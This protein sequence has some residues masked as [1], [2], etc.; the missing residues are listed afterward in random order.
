MDAGWCV[1][2]GGGVLNNGQSPN[3][4]DLLFY[5]RTRESLREDALTTLP[6]GEWSVSPV[7][8]VYVY[9]SE[10]RRVEVIFQ[11]WVPQ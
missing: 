4:L 6:D 9:Y 11:T 8:D 7:S 10:D 5:P 1:L 2:L 3:D